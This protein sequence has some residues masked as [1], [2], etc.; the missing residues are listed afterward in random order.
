MKGAKPGA[1]HDDLPH[2]EE[3]LETLTAKRGLSRIGSA[4]RTLMRGL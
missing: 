2:P 3:S 4:A 1:L